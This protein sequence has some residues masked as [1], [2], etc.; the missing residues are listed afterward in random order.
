MDKE[1]RAALEGLRGLFYGEYGFEGFKLA[2]EFL[3]KAIEIDPDESS[4]NFLKG[5]YLSRLRH[6][7]RPQDLPNAEEMYHLELSAS[8]KKNGTYSLFLAQMYQEMAKCYFQQLRN[9]SGL[10]QEEYQ[11]AKKKSSELNEKSHK[12]YK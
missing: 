5:K 2:V 11:K 12:L 10:S 7:E 9:S 3:S 1:N 6:V 4:W 8:Q